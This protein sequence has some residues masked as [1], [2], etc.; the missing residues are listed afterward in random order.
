MPGNQHDPLKGSPKYYRTIVI[1][2]LVAFLIEAMVI[3]IMNTRPAEN[4]LVSLFGEKIAFLLQL[5]FWASIGATISSSIFLSNDKNL[6]E[7][8]RAKDKPDPAILRYPNEIDVWL[9]AQRILTSG[10]LGV[11]GASLFIVGL[12]YFELPLE[13]FKSKHKLF[14]A[15]VSFIIGLYQS[16]FLTALNSFSKKL[17]QQRSEKEGKSDNN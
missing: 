11:I 1:L 9:Y 8:E 3:L 7:L 12:W 17:F 6:N 14:L 13:E 16:D 10:F 2:L 4:A 5:F 15:I